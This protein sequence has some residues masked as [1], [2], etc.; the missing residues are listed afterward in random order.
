V[1]G[2]MG[3]C[4]GPEGVGVHTGGSVRLWWLG[5]RY[6]GVRDSGGLGGVVR[7]SGAVVRSCGGR[8]WCGMVVLRM[9]DG[10]IDG[11]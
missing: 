6:M 11:W 10:R 7:G 5:V 8:G 1:R 9:I 2:S 3:W 4:R